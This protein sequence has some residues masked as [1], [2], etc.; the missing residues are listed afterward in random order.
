MV[1][2]SWGVAYAISMFISGFIAERVDLRHFLTI[3]MI[4]T[5]IG[6]VLFGISYYAQIH[7]LYYFIIIRI[8]SGAMQVI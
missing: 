7:M 2:N 6:S 4:G 1:D 3:G 8:F 5:S